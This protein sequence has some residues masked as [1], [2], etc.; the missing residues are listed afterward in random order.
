LSKVRV[1]DP[2]DSDLL[3]NDVIERYRHAQVN[4]DLAGSLKVV[5]AG[6]T[7]LVNGKVYPKDEIKEANA[8]A[9]EAGREPAKT[10]KTKPAR[11]R[12]L[13][14]GI[15]KASLQSESFL[16]GASFQE[17]TKV[18]TEAALKGAVDNLLG[19]KENVLLGHLIPAGTGF[20]T[21]Q[22]AE[23]R[24]RPEALES[25]RLDRESVL[26]RDF[27]LLAAAPAGEDAPQSAETGA[28]MATLDEEPGVL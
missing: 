10:V 16:S 6:G 3:P 28:D 25:L 19:L 4:N 15:T 7:L 18:L 27:P 8:T 12:T 24:V 13:L 14:L 20:N 9:E 5:D 2:G 23:V 22:S 1:S 17:T 11:V 21:F 26:A